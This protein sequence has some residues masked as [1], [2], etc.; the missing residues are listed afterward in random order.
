MYYSKE[1]IGVP[2]MEKSKIL[3]VATLLF[4]LVVGMSACSK[5]SDDT[6]LTKKGSES[7]N[8]SE[9]TNNLHAESIDKS[10]NNGNNELYSS[11]SDDEKEEGK[12]SQNLH[13]PCTNT[14]TNN[15]SKPVNTAKKTG[16]SHSNDSSSDGKTNSDN[17][18]GKPAIVISSG[19]K[20]IEYLKLH[21]PEGKDDDVS[22]GVDETLAS[23]DNGTYYTIQ[24]VSVSTRVS[25]K[26]GTLGYYKV[27]QDG[28]YKSF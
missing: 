6:A 23:D 18:E 26:T 14:S 25:G 2:I 8:I 4:V 28:T 15:Q 22:F 16:S 20:A 3:I 21:L 5:S 12:P 10:H 7:N 1:E 17:S 11:K 24:L 13:E 9:N 27:Y 19:E